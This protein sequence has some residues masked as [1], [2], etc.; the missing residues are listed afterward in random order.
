MPDV[1]DENGNRSKEEKHK[2]P[3]ALGKATLGSDVALNTVKTGL[4]ECLGL[5][6]IG[7]RQLTKLSYFFFT[8]W[9][10]Q[11]PPKASPLERCDCFHSGC[12]ELFVR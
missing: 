3:L 1:K 12:W 8:A 4:L 5:L 2:K 9:S 6:A 11:L 7:S 10:N